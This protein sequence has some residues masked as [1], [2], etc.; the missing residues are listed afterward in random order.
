MRRRNEVLVGLF[1]TIALIIM[2][3]GTIWLTRGGFRRGYPLYAKFSWGQNLKNGHPILLAGQTV[4]YVS[5]VELQSGYLDVEL[6]IT[7]KQGIPRGSTASVIPVGIFGDVA[8]SFK[9]PLPLPPTNYAAGD[10]VPVGAG[11][12]D[13]GAILA[14]VDTIGTSI[15]RLTSALEAE[16]VQGGGLRDLRRSVASMSRVSE[17]LY[18][19]MAN[20]DRNLTLLIGDARQS[21]TRLAGML[22][23]AQIDSTVRNTKAMTANGVRLIAVLDS[24]AAEMRTLVAKA[25]SGRG[26]L[27][28]LL[29]DTTMYTNARN[30]VATLDSV[31]LDFKKN[32]TKYIN[33]KISVF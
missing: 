5:N 14:R 8:I 31:M 22:D 19:V 13:M 4:G 28:M 23:S 26:S 16:F 20:Q 21:M 9:P 3:A 17:Q 29:N 24:T 7:S 6:R 27:G 11:P 32:P 12:P 25:N 10:T 30:L 18:T 15:S 2:I 33:V 1:V